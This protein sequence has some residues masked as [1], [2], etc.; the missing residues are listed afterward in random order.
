[1][2][3][4]KEASASHVTDLEKMYHDKMEKLM[5]EEREKKRME[6]KQL[7]ERW[8][9]EIEQR[10]MRYCEEMKKEGEIE[11]IEAVNRVQETH[12]N[13]IGIMIISINDTH[14]Y[15]HSITYPDRLQHA[16]E[17][18]HGLELR[19]LQNE[20]ERERD[21]WERVK[22]LLESQK[23]KEVNNIILKYET[24]ID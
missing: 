18:Q 2:E 21:D 6:I 14:L 4:E 10:E 22:Q 17:E 7:N 9:R 15:D 20:Q 8:S 3:C 5:M 19:K 23:I 24:N 13:K 12:R 11:K 1:M 16:L